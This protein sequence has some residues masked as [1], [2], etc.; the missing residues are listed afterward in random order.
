MKKKK[1][2]RL[3]N[4][5]DQCEKTVVEKTSIF[6]AV[7]STTMTMERIQKKRKSEGNLFFFQKQKR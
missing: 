6:D 5:V 7:A 3:H 1:E 4:L 2:E